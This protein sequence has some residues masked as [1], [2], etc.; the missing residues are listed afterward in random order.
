[1]GLSKLS[2][3]L[4]SLVESGQRPPGL[5]QKLKLRV[6]REFA[7]D[8]RGFFAHYSAMH[9]LQNPLSFEQNV[10]SPMA[11]GLVVSAALFANR[12]FSSV[13]ARYG[14]G[15]GVAHLSG[16]VDRLYNSV[17]FKQ[18]LCERD[19]PVQKHP[20]SGSGCGPGVECASG[21]LS[22]KASRETN[23]GCPN[24]WQKTLIIVDPKTLASR[25]KVTKNLPW[26]R[27]KRK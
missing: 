15:S 14:L 16:L 18:I 1:M 5:R 4:T 25:S 2:H 17:D 20:H 24:E 10:S 27:C 12:Y 13:N 26:S 7:R 19:T 8:P 9:F 21:K 3:T 22:A 6:E 11:T 23:T